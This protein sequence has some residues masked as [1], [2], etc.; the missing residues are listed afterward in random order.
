MNGAKQRKSKYGAVSTTVDGIR[1]DSKKEAAR[2]LELKLLLRAGEIRALS[3]QPEYEFIHRGKVICKYRAD[4]WYEEIKAGVIIP[5]A[6][7]P[8]D[9][10][11]SVVEDVKGVKTP[12]YRLKKKMMLIFYGIEIRET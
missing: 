4:F 11:S 12:V 1:F 6:S 8:V 10:W 9:I 2:H 5:G 7:C 3:L